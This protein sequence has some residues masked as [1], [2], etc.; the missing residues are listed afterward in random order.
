MIVCHPLL[1][2][3]PFL[4]INLVARICVLSSGS[5]I[6]YAFFHVFLC[7]DVEP[8]IYSDETAFASHLPIAADCLGI[9]V[10]R[11]ASFLAVNCFVSLAYT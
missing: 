2:Q 5:V 9:F 11:S 3:Y 8:C 1:R 4:L 7:R 10:D 6:V